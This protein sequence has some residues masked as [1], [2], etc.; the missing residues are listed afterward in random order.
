MALYRK[1]KYCGA[2]LSF[3]QMPGG[4][5][6]AFD[7][8]SD[9]V[10]QCRHQPIASSENPPVGRSESE[11]VV[12][13][14]YKDVLSLLTTAIDSYQCVKL[15]YFTESRG[16]VTERVVEPMVLHQCMVE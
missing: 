9:I 7:V 12:A 1:C 3:R 10:H 13:T 15:R 8:G 16:A 5:W 11:S 6:V 4:H 2:R 14:T